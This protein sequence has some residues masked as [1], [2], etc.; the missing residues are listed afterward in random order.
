MLKMI[1]IRSLS[2]Y[3]GMI[4]DEA[5]NVRKIQVLH[6]NLVLYKIDGDVVTILHIR[7]GRMDKNILP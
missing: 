7:A 2:I 4:Y 1:W 6:K 3:A 5:L